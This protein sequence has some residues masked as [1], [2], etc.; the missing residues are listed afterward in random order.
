MCSIMY[1]IEQKDA[2]FEVLIEDYF[3]CD[4]RDSDKKLFE[5]MVKEWEIR[6]GWEEVRIRQ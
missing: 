6:R 4:L 2:S 1:T 5:A 3:R